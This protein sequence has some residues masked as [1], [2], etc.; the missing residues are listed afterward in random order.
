M[1]DVQEK[2][3]KRGFIPYLK[4]LLKAYPMV[5]IERLESGYDY[6]VILPKSLASEFVKTILLK[7]PKVEGVGNWLPY[8]MFGYYKRLRVYM[9]KS[10]KRL[11]AEAGGATREQLQLPFEN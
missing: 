6:N 1:S 10:E 7:S 11:K 5:E 2:P 3:N 4:A 8:D 9:R